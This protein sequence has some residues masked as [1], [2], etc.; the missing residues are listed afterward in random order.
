M[1]EPCDKTQERARKNLQ[2]ILQKLSSVGQETV[3]K[4]LNLSVATISRMTA[5]RDVN[6]R[7]RPSEL[8]ELATALA[9]LGLK[10]VPVGV[11]CYNPDDIEPLFQLARRHLAQLKSIEELSDE[12]PE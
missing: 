12:D 9:A 10:T 4:A 1:T 8:E 7:T 2:M 3:A 5:P 6:G 11:R